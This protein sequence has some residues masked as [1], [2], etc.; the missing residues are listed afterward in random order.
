MP[1]AGQ[2]SPSS[3]VGDWGAGVGAGVGSGEGVQ[4]RTVQGSGWVQ[5]GCT[6]RATWCKSVYCLTAPHNWSIS[7]SPLVRVKLIKQGVCG[8]DVQAAVGINQAAVLERVAGLQRQRLSRTSEKGSCG[9]T[10]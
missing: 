8:L 1:S 6:I 10:T 3:A 4:G 9:T 7:N 5:G 2:Q